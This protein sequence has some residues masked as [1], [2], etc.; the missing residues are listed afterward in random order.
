[1]LEEPH[2]R[3]NPQ[4]EVAAEHL[5]RQIELGLKT[6]VATNPNRHLFLKVSYEA[7]S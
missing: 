7:T 3:H 2:E 5:K 6:V 1:M 4:S